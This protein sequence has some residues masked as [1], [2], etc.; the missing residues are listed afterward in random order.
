MKKIITVSLAFL[1]L[2]GYQ[3]DAQNVLGRLGQRAKNAA[4]N[5]VGNK[6]QRQIEKSIDDIGTNTGNNN[7]KSNQTG[8]YSNDEQPAKSAASTVADG[9]WTCPS[10]GTTGI[11]GKFCPECGTKK[12]E[13]TGPAA[14]TC[15][16]CGHTGNTGKFCDE[17]GAP[18][19]YGAAVT[20]QA[21]KSD[22]VPGDIV[23]FEDKVEGEQIGEFPSKWDLERGNAEI[24]VIN[25][26][27]AIAMDQSDCWITPL[28]ID[29][30][31]GA[32]SKNYLGDIFSIEFDMLFDDRPKD[33]CPSIEFDIM[34]PERHRDQEI[35]TFWWHPGGDLQDINCHYVKSSEASNDYKEG[36]SSKRDVGPVNDGRWHHFAVSFNQRALKFYVDDVRVIN[37]PAAKA[38]AGWFT[39]YSNG[40][41][42]PTYLK[43]V[44]V[45][46]GGGELYGRQATDVSAAAAAVEKAMAASG[47][48]VTNNILFETGKATLK[49]ESMEDINAVA[50]YMKKNPSVRFEVQGHCDNQGSDKV[51][52]P[53]S[54]QRAEAIVAEL[55]KLGVDEWNLRAVGKGS[56]EPVA[57]NSTEEGRAKN[58]RVEF[59]KK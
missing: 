3:C 43:N 53:L 40:G 39:L 31:T 24:Q 15:E 33:G 54:Q 47:K 20:T 29:P 21:Q 12:P 46:K 35:Y 41:P 19:G 2:L 8:E 28:I 52:D 49:P 27:Q 44:R 25:G 14:W 1:L 42:R 18:K 56:H 50:D 30:A 16:K 23:M 4:E 48:F 55:V 34:A 6:I 45:A 59:I 51:N 10:C 22:F 5:A 58:R 13:G 36:S 9:T 11:T 26:V 17:C 57:D 37:V 38:G 7:N 32:I